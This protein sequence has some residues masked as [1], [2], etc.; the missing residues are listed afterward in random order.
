MLDKN[1]YNGLSSFYIIEELEGEELGTEGIYRAVW[2]DEEKRKE[3]PR[4][5]VLVEQEEKILAYWGT[6]HVVEVLDEQ[7]WP[8]AYR[9][10]NELQENSFKRMIA[11]GALN[12]NYGTKKTWQ[13]D[14]HQQRARNRLEEELQKSSQRLQRRTS[15]V[16]EQQKKVQESEH[17]GHGK[18]LPQRQRKLVELEQK[19]SA[20]QAREEQL[21]TRLAETGEPKQRADRDFRK[22][23]VM[24]LRT[25]L[26]E[27]Y[28]RL[29]ME[30]LLLPLGITVS[31][32]IILDLLFK[33]S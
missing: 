22:Q 15:E 20:E 24:T 26:L 17:R 14:R 19:K 29:F 28:L 27:N 7:E 12:T 18:R 33:R 2:K 25:L 5:F 4:H 3:D 16:V 1:E 31:I 10:R 8:K 13:S 6:S 21:K 32:E 11:H 9:Q 30:A 23:K